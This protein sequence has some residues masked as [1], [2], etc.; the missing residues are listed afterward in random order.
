MEITVAAEM[1]RDEMALY[2]ERE[3]RYVNEKIEVPIGHWAWKRL[4]EI[5]ETDVEKLPPWTGWQTS[6]WHRPE[7]PCWIS[8]VPCK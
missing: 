4:R 5:A 7:C 1:L 8:V 2:N 6:W 3:L